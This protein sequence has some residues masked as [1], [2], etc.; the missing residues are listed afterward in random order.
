MKT[1]DDKNISMIQD[2]KEKY[3]YYMVLDGY[4][5]GIQYKLGSKTK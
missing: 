3:K 2:K 4:V 1:T 5:V